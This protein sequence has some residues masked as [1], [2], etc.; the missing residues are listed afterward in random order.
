MEYTITDIKG[1]YD[2]NYPDSKKYKF[3]VQGYP[4][5]LSAF[6]K[7]PMTVGQEISGEI[8]VKGQYHN[9]KWGKKAGARPASG[10]SPEQFQRLSDKLDATNTNALRAIALIQELA[11]TLRDAGVIKQTFGDGTDDARTEA[12]NMPF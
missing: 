5:E 3:T 6:S 8:E 11:R 4:H 9:F 1:I 10:M 2:S 7:F 12:D